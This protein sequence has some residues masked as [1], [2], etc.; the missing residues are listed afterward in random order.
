M[1]C[2]GDQGGSACICFTALT[3]LLTTAL[4]PSPEAT[5]LYVQRHTIVNSEILLLTVS[6]TIPMLRGVSGLLDTQGNLNPK[7][8]AQKLSD[9]ISFSF[10]VLLITS[11]YCNHS[12]ERL[13]VSDKCIHGCLMDGYVKLYAL[14]S[15]CVL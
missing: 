7:E 1:E 14:T 4:S 3:P 15:P 2:K 6:K 5:T 10:S 12:W 11:Y 9:H 8:R 13:V